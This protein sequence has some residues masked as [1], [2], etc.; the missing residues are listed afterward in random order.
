[1]RVYNEFKRQETTFKN[2]DIDAFYTLFEQ[3]SQDSNGDGDIIEMVKSYSQKSTND[4]S[5]PKGPLGK[6]IEKFLS[7]EKSSLV[8]VLGE[9]RMWKSSN[10]QY[11]EVDK[12]LERQFQEK[13]QRLQNKWAIKGSNKKNFGVKLN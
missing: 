3:M 2:I 6:D 9:I 10:I 8:A 12:V 11:E 1:M 13:Q 5:G 7:V 4:N